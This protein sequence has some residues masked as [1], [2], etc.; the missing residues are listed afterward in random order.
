MPSQK[1]SVLFNG[2]GAQG[3]LSGRSEDGLFGR[4][5]A[6]RVTSARNV[7]DSDSDDPRLAASGWPQVNFSTPVTITAGTTYIASYHAAGN[8]SADPNL[9]ANSVT[10]GPLTAPSSASSGGNGVYAYGT[11]SLFPT[12]TF[13]STSY[14][15]DVIFRPQLAA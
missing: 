8:Y 15:V 14:A 4:G 13:N 2:R 12:N 9:F 3:L 6:W 7:P 5:P 1:T 10:N 11:G